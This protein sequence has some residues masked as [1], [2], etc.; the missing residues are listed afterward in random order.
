MT[1]TA[2]PTTPWDPAFPSIVAD[3]QEIPVR[4]WASDAWWRLDRDGVPEGLLSA[5]FWHG[6]V[7]VE[8]A[9]VRPA[10]RSW[11]AIRA[12]RAAM[13]RWA[14]AHGVARV[15]LGIPTGSP[16]ALGLA[17]L[18]CRIYA[19]TEDSEWWTRRLEAHDGR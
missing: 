5:R 1:W 13:F 19:V 9:I 3:G 4:S 6:E 18:G 14:R 16:W 10:A 17:R 2:V 8:H 11:A 7:W 12:M 15:N